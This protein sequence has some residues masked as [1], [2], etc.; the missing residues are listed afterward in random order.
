MSASSAVDV[1]EP[2]LS[3]DLADTVST[4]D[5]ENLAQMVD[6]DA[7]RWVSEGSKPRRIEQG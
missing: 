2:A 7:G 3:V 6:H 1:T 5:E 4:I